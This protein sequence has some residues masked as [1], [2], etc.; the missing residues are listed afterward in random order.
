MSFIL[1]FSKGG[2]TPK[3][4]LYSPPQLIDFVVEHKVSSCTMTTTQMKMLL[5]WPDKSKLLEWN[6]LKTFVV[7]GEEVPPWV[8]REFF[9]LGL[10]HAALYNGYGPTE[11]T[12]CNSLKK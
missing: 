10:P 12:V 9:A 2:L 3:V 4:A 8:V 6:S 7:G 1:A 11:T 5:A